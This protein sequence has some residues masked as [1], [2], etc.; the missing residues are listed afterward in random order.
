MTK[1]INQYN[2]HN[3][4]LIGSAFLTNALLLRLNNNQYP[5]LLKFTLTTRC[6]DAPFG[7]SGISG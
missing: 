3:V 5:Y 7:L 1:A 2:F 4:S 6:V